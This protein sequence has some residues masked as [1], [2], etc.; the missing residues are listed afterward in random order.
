MKTAKHKKI[1]VIFALVFNIESVTAQDIQWAGLSYVSQSA[2]VKESFPYTSQ[3]ESTLR[4]KVL[5][6][7][8]R[9]LS[10]NL[11]YELTLG[12]RDT[13]RDGSLSFGSSIRIRKY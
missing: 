9:A 6:T 10:P 2:D 3:L 5:A 13:Y 7:N 11:N 8:L 12:G 1:F 4:S